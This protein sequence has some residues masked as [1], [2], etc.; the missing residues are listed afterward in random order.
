VDSRIA[1]A[2]KVRLDF[3]GRLHGPLSPARKNFDEDRQYEQD[4]DRRE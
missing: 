2:N 1:L 3:F 4:K